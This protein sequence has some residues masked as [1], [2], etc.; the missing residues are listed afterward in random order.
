M[1]K[2]GNLVLVH[3]G[4]PMIGPIANLPKVFL[5]TGHE[6]SGL[7]LALGTAEMVSDMILETPSKLDCTPSQS[8]AGLALS[9]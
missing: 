5:A 2:N 4:K 8:K 7:S 1:D 6:G 9:Y 3:D